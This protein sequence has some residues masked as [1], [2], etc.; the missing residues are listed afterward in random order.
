MPELFLPIR[1]EAAFQSW[2]DRA[3]PGLAEAVRVKVAQAGFVDPLSDAGQ[4]AADPS[5]RGAA[6]RA[7]QLALRVALRRQG[8]AHRQDLRII[9]R[10]DPAPSLHRLGLLES[11]AALH[12]AGRAD[13]LIGDAGGWEKALP[14]VRPG[15]IVV[16]PLGAAIGP[17]GWTRLARLRAA[18]FADAA[19]VL[20]ASGRHAIAGDADGAVPVLVGT[21]GTAGAPLP[22]MEAPDGL[23]GRFVA[24]LALPRSGTT[25]LTAMFQVHS[26]VDAVFEP[27]NGKVLDGA[28]EASL[29][30][31]LRQAGIA[32]DPGRSLFVKETAAHL[33]Y[34][35]FFRRM[36]DGSALPLDRAVLMLLRKPAHTF[37]S[38]VERRGQ[39]WGDQVPLDA[40]QFGLWCDKYR[41]AV[42]GMLRTLRDHD[43]AA[44]AFEA[45]AADPAALL[46]RI[47]AFTGLPM[48]PTQ[49][50]YEQ[51]LD[52][53]QVRGDL[54]VGERP[55]PISDDSVRRRAQSEHLVARFAAEGPHAA[56]FAAFTALHAAVAEAGIIRARALPAALLDPLG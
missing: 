15:G 34:L 50:R 3:P 4:H 52:R 18:G 21:L 35:A 42:A 30:V 32:P 43:G 39:W 49:L 14:A 9:A 8:W 22:W 33:E 7:L 20:I 55:A 11:H 48:E 17:D 29:P 47:A 23:P 53:S 44:L 45:L 38:E 31:L 51:H 6:Q 19:V 41:Q 46:P 40:R 36:I 24:L 54:N 10:H 37:L 5:L 13:V 56:W 2:R 28:E 12:A 26:Q 1:D 16:A 27:W 25:L